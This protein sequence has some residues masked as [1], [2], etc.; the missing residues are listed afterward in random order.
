VERAVL[1]EEVRDVL[2]RE[3]ARRRERH[4]RLHQWA[5]RMEVA[6]FRG[7]PL[8][9]AALRQGVDTLRRCGVGG[10][11]SREHEG[12]LLLCWRS[13]PL[14]SVSAWRPDRG[15]AYGVGSGYLSPSAPPPDHC[16][17]EELMC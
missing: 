13:W 11:E 3:G 10:C 2:L 6:G 14:Y 1:G 5:R 9:Y 7:V 17:E 16:F 4:D 8:S 15:S 12:C